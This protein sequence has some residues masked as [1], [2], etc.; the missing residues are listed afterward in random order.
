MEGDQIKFGKT[1]FIG[2]NNHKLKEHYELLKQLA[3]GG[4][5]KVY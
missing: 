2:L 3:K 1:T 5:G 4:Y